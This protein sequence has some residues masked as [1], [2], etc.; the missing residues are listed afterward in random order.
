MEVEAV[1][2]IFR[3]VCDSDLLTGLHLSM[4]LAL[5]GGGQILCAVSSPSPGS[6]TVQKT[7]IVDNQRVGLSGR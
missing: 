2:E 4:P 5:G 6:I 7:I 3:A 1:P